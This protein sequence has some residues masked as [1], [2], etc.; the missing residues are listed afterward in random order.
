M[1]APL[2]MQHAALGRIAS[3]QGALTAL[4]YVYNS[5]SYDIA[6]LRRAAAPNTSAPRRSGLD[7]TP[8]LPARLARARA[9][10]RASPARGAVLG[11]R[12]RLVS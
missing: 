4:H 3:D 5:V 10:A 1:Q 8:R 11:L 12:A 9:S 6:G 7:R 2:S